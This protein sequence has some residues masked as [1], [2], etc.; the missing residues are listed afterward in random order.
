MS[1]QHS[2]K[3]PKVVREVQSPNRSRKSLTITK[4]DLDWASSQGAISSKQSDDVWNA[5]QSRFAN[6]PQFDLANLAWYFGALLV[7][8]AMGWFMV[9]LVDNFGAGGLLATSIAYTLGFIAFGSKLWFRDN[10]KVPGG[11]LFTLAVSMTPLTVASI[12]QLSNVNWDSS[13]SMLAL[14]LSTVAA[15]AL[16]LRFVKF[17]FLTAPIYFSLWLVSITLLDMFSGSHSSWNSQ[18]WMSAGFGAAILAVA[19]VTDRKTEEDY[20][21]WGY[22]FGMVSLWFSLT[23]MDSG[24]ELWKLAYCGLNVGFLFASVLL[25][26]RVFALFGTLGVLV[27]LGHLSYTLFAGSLLFPLALSALGIGVIVLGIK[28][29]RNRNRI[30]AYLRGLVPGSLRSRFPGDSDEDLLN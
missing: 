8:V 20:S 28:Y 14:E 27:Y 18:L 22:L 16:A 19:F 9:E 21:F 7:L 15:G 12:M 1:S 10:L 2:G 25:G 29:H 24:S 13:S 11:L 6:K 5:L 17:P 4:A 3:G 23:L 30:E 26:R